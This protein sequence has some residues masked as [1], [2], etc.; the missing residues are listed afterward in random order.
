M[1]LKGC[2]YSNTLQ[3][4][5][6]ITIVTP[7]IFRAEGNYKVTYLLHGLCG[8][9]DSWLDYS[10]LAS[11]ARSGDVVYVLPEV[12]RSFY[13]DME[14]GLDYYTYIS[15]ELPEI[16]KSVFNI[17]AKSEDTSIIGNSMGGFGAL[18]IALNNPGNYGYCGAFSPAFMY[19]KEDL[20]MQKEYGDDEE[21]IQTY[22]KQFVRDFRSAF[23]EKLEYK[24]EN[25]LVKLACKHKDNI[26][27]KFYIACGNQDFLK[28]LNDRFANDL[29]ELG[30]DLNY[31]TWDGAHD[32][33]FF[34]Q[35]L[36]RAIQYIKNIQL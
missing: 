34:D 19:I 13:T 30:Y 35:A 9:H 26:N 31:E 29:M 15:K 36:K 17:S 24:S 14:N 7:N 12:G 5:T 10:M 27:T 33:E 3:M 21:F 8:N 2:V 1:I 22:G 18:K 20:N 23:G 4:D 28:E 16:C 6:G 25:D 11:Y 32:F